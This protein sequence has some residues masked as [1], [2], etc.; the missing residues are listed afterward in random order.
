M[1]GNGGR[2]PPFLTC[3]PDGGPLY[4]PLPPPWDNIHRIGNWAG[5]RAGL[6]AVDRRKILPQTGIESWPSS[7]Y[8]DEYGGV[9]RK[10]IVFCSTLFYLSCYVLHYPLV[11]T[12]LPLVTQDLQ[13]SCLCCWE[14]SAETDRQAVWN[15]EALMKRKE[16]GH[17]WS[18]A[19]LRGRGRGPGRRGLQSQYTAISSIII[20][21]LFSLSE[22]WVVTKLRALR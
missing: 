20:I 7:M 21:N 12:T 2:A 19:G 8:I 1:W 13:E 4:R 9:G 6:D 16:R 10:R 5:P 3:A 14:A 22:S 11:Y 15:W 17:M 18:S